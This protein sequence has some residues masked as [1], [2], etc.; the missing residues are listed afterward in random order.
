[1]VVEIEM[2]PTDSCVC[3]LHSLGVILTGDMALMEKV[4]YCEVG[5]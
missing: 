2:A 4:C 1:M 5:L 3:K